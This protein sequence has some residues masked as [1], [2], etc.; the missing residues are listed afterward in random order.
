LKAEAYTVMT[1]GIWKKSIF[2]E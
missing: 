1:L 2:R